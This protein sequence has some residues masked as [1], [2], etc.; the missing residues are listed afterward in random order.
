MALGEKLDV[1]DIRLDM[2][3]RPRQAAGE[4]DLPEGMGLDAYEQE[5]IKN[6]LKQAD[7]SKSQAVRISGLTRAVS[8]ARR[9]PPASVPDGEL[10]P[11]RRSP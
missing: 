7:G 2:N 4:A 3:P 6:A 10:R 11:E 5:P 8:A 9:V 1:N